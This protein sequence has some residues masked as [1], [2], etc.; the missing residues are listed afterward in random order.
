MR[1][2]LFSIG[3]SRTGSLGLASAL[4]LIITQSHCGTPKQKDGVVAPVAKKDDIAINNARPEGLRLELTS[5]RAEIAA[6]QCAV[7]RLS[8]FN[9]SGRPTH[10]GKGWVF[11]QQG[12]TPPSPEAFPRSDLELPPGLTT[13]FV[14]VRVCHAN[15]TPGTY[16]YRIS[17]APASADSPRSNWLTLQVRP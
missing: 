3:G 15:L 12:P 8:A 9:T 6:G 1:S 16:R 14:S 5:D 17:A 10:W 13:D 2:L 4:A 7:L 11:E